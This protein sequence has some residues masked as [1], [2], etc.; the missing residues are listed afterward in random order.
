MKTVLKASV[1]CWGVVVAFCV[2]FLIPFELMGPVA[3]AVLSVSV[4]GGLLAWLGVYIYRLNKKEGFEFGWFMIRHN[5]FWRLLAGAVGLAL[6]SVGGA[7]L[8]APRET[9]RRLGQAAMPFAAFLV[10][11]FWFS[12]IFTFLGFSL[13]CF[14]ESAAYARI[15]D[16]KSGAGSFALSTFWLG[17]ATL[18]CSLF[19]EVIDDNFLGLS[20]A[21]QNLILC[22]FALSVAGGGLFAGWYKDLEK[23]LPEEELKKGVQKR[24]I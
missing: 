9:E 6:F 16:F 10:V 15:K 23:L 11:L 17:L 22:L 20:G 5:G 19:L 3:A 2:F 24:T 13:V 7:W 4:G 8:L 12:L 21:T 1:F 14:A 18:F